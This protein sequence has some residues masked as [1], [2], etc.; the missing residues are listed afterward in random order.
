[1]KAFAI[2]AT[3]AVVGCGVFAVGAT[4]A[5]PIAERQQLMKTIARSTKAA[6]EMVQGKTAY[7]AAAA[8]EAMAAIAAAAETFPTLFPHGTE[9]GGDTEA[10]PKIWVDGAGFEIG[11]RKLQDA[12]VAA[13]TAAEGGLDAF[14]PAFGA[15]AGTCKACHETYR[16]SK[17]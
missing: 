10:S 1:M 13:T 3:V 14:K 15:V 12:A 2:A 8:K 11:A 9:T 5:D 17:S 6:A 16:I 7:D 4:A